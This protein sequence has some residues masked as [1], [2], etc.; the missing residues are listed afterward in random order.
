M[1]LPGGIGMPIDLA[2]QETIAHDEQAVQV[3]RLLSPSLDFP[4]PC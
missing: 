4:N 2:D 1:G 3:E